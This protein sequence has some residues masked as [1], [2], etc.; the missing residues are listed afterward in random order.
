MAGQPLSL[1]DI[2]HGLLR[3]DRASPNPLRWGFWS[4]RHFLSATDPRRAWA[5]P[6]DPRIHFALNCG[7]LSCPAV[8]FYEGASLGEELQ[9]AAEAFLAGVEGAS[10]CLGFGGG[11][12]FVFLGVG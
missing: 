6:L 12:V 10:L 3:G 1:D 7:A 11:D 8:R 5:V 2:E 9:A 4:R